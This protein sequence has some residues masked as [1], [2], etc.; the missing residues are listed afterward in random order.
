MEDR[1]HSFIMKVSNSVKLCPSS[2]IP[3]GSYLA[4]IEGKI[5]DLSGSANGRKK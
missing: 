2:H 4:V 5:Q 1:G 3:D